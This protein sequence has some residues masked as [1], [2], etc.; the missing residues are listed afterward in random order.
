VTGDCEPQLMSSQ[1]SQ[2]TER[3]Q[4]KWRQVVDTLIAHA[5]AFVWPARCILCLGKGESAS[6]LCHACAQDLPRNG[7]FC[8]T[9]AQPL[10][11]GAGTRLL[12]GTC[13][14]TSPSFD[15]AFIPYRYAYPLDRMIQRLKYGNDLSMGRVLA[16]CFAERLLAERKEPLPAA[17]VPVPLGSKR[18]RARGYNQ[19]IELARHLRKLAGLRMQTDL[20][21][22]TR[23]TP[24]QAA[25]PRDERR[26]N[27][28]GAFALLQPLECTHIAILDDVVTTGSTVN[29]IAKLLQSAGATRI[30]VWAIAR[31]GK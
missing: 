9:C 26:K 30:E 24:E 14:R 10:A 15:S 19:A 2:P 7:N 17:I 4:P 5:G 18:F 16:I 1:Y 27:V 6:D 11:E 29:E 23:E 28:R 12:C 3:C 8:R 21:A 25:L 31:A 13:V 20:V 22:R